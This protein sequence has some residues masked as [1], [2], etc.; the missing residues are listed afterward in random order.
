MTF[1][2]AMGGHAHFIWP[3]YGIAA[4]VLSGLA[5]AAVRRLARSEADLAKLEAETTGHGERRS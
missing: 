2:P 1:F 5:L 4:L 3:A